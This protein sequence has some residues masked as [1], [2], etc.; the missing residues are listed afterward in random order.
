MVRTPRPGG[1]RELAVFL[2][3]VAVLALTALGA[4]SAG[5]KERDARTND[6][7]QPPAP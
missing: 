2:L 5:S 6:C 4:G 7:G 1:M 3:A